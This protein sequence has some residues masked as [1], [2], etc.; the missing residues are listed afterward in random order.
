MGP[1]TS[2]LS[3][4]GN[5]TPANAVIHNEILVPAVTQGFFVTKLLDKLFNLRR[6]SRLLTAELVAG[7]SDNGKPITKLLL[8]FLK[9]G[10][11]PSEA[12]KAG[13]CHG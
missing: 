1:F 2:I 13:D 4:T 5:V 6:R 3:I 11:L 10:I 12:T 7:K 9:P 8:E